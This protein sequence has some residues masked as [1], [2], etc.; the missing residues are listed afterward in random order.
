MEVILVNP[1][2]YHGIPVIR[3]ERCEI[4]ERYSVLPPYSLLQ[5]ASLLRQEGHVVHLVDANGD[6]IGYEE[7]SLQLERLSY[8]ALIFRFTPTT[9][10]WDM[11]TAKLSKALH[12]EATTVGI[13]WTLRTLPA[14]VL[15]EA[16]EL[17]IYLRH[18]Y[19]VVAVGLVNALSKGAELA[20]TPGI[21]Y[22]EGDSVR[23]THDAEPMPCYESLPIPAYDLLSDLNRYY[24]NTPAGRPF[25]IMYTSRGCPFGCIFC[26]VARTKWKNR[27]APSI[28]RELGYLKENYGVKTVSFFDESF[29]VDRQRVIE[30]S[31]GMAEARLD[32]RWYCNT[33]V[34]LVDE[35]LLRVMYRGGC[36][37]ISFGV[38]SGSQC[39]LDNAHKGSTVEQAENAVRWAKRV[40]I[41]VYCSFIFGLPGETRDTMKE[42]LGFIR[43][44]L[45]T[46]AQ[47]NVAVPYPGTRLH[48]MV[49]G[50]QT[51]KDWRSLYQD[52]SV[53]GTDALSPKDLNRARLVAYRSLYSNPRWWAQNIWHVVKHPEDFEMASKY[54][55]KIADNYLLHRMRH[56]H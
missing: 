26:T 14:E 9:F 18:E 46:G 24:I 55:L 2:R 40:G 44:V 50:R 37:G 56:A 10:D 4:T 38:E 6:S 8:Q 41:K 47:F 36:R 42:T 53:M 11:E 51:S 1:P 3:E 45:P 22:R 35:E 49:N 30:L 27:G 54:V 19:E 28:L 20:S 48:E 29:T 43:R 5:I 12:P 13:C 16:P 39:I 32:I 25:T 33:R 21:A 17:D 31:N 34:E 23:V 7:L 52:L 15:G